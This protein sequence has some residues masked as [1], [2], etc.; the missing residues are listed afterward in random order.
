MNVSTNVNIDHEGPSHLM[1][2][3]KDAPEMAL[4]GSL[5]R[6]ISDSPREIYAP[7]SIKKNA[8]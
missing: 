5:Q 2:L 3:Q 8:K 7:A 1:S 4:S 6:R